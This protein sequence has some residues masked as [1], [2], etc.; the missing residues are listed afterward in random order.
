VISGTSV[1][2]GAIAAQCVL[3]VFQALFIWQQRAHDR[4]QLATLDDRMMA[5][6][7]LSRA[8]IDCEM[9]KPFWRI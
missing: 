7:G 3:V 9:R 6:M 8:D 5:D 4:H 1:A 2:L